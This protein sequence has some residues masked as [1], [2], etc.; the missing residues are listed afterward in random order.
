MASHKTHCLSGHSCRFLSLSSG[1]SSGWSRHSS[2]F[3]RISSGWW[4]PTDPF[5]L[6]CSPAQWETQRLGISWSDRIPSTLLSCQLSP[7]RKQSRA[8]PGQVVSSTN[9][10]WDSWCWRSWWS[11]RFCQ[12]STRSIPCSEAVAS[13]ISWGNGFQSWSCTC[14]IYHKGYWHCWLGPSSPCPW[15]ISEWRWWLPDRASCSP[16]DLSAWGRIPF[17]WNCLFQDLLSPVTSTELLWA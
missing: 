11:I 12:A 17:C 1:L 8:C 5:L 4:G 9:F 7:C 3:P 14:W 15:K 16:S 13:S 2:W 10:G 6:G